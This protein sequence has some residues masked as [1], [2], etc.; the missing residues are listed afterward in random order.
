MHKYLPSLF[1]FLD[2]YNSQ[3]FKN[4]NT[5]IGI[6]YRNYNE[7]KRENELI[8]IAKACK[9]NRYQLFVSNNVKLALKFKADGIYIPSFNKTKYFLNLEKKNVV[10]LGSAHNQQEI[11]KKI[12]QNCSAVFLSPLFNVNKSKKFLGLHQFNYLSYMNKINIFALGGISEN[13][14]RKLKLLYI[15]GFGGIRIFKKKP[16]Y[17]RP[18][19]SKNNFF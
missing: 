12:S 18:V 3:I 16:A 19:F 14:I 5:N 11:Q 10:I 8:K 1:I 9:K 6:I 13:N 4:K 17:K 7:R 2:Q 15:S